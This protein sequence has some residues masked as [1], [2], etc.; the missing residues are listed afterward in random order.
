MLIS[1]YKAELISKSV[2]IAFVT[3]K[4]SASNRY[5]MKKIEVH[6]VFVNRNLGMRVQ[7]DIKLFMADISLAINLWVH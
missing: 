1:S 4:H 5:S 3:A 2:L 6:D 7:Q